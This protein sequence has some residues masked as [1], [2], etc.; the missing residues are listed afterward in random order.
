MY[1]KRNGEISPDGRW[2]SYQSN[3]SGRWEIYVRPFPDVNS[4]RWQVSTMGGTQ[5]LWARNGQELFYVA[6]DGTL[7]RAAI[8]RAP[9]GPQ[10]GGQALPQSGGQAWR[11]GTP[12]KLFDNTYAWTV[13]G[14]GARSYDISADGRRFLAMKPVSAEQTGA[15]SNL[16]VV[17]NWFEELNRRVPAA[18]K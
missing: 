3:E 1:G 2:M 15:P 11:A 17:Q 14:F 13:P 8:E 18:T 12:A 16:I 7:M 6:L 10:S 5:P 4:G 9:A